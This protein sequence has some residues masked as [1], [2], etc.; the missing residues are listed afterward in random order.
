MFKRNGYPKRFIQAVITRTLN[1]IPNN[2]EQE[3]IF[4]K[5]PYVSEQLKRRALSVIRHSGILNIKTHFMNSGP[6]SKVFAP[7]REKLNCPDDCETCKLTLKTNCCLTKHVV[8]QVMCS[9]CNI[10]YIGETGRTVESRIKEHLRMK[11]QTVFVHLKSHPDNPLEESPFSW[12][13]LH[14]NVKSH[15]ERKIIEAL[16]LEIQ[17]HS[18]IMN[19]CIGRNICI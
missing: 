1:T 9:N 19:G 6:S 15:S 7:S 4:L 5:I 8:Y 12:K 13:I 16:V 11:K 2:D 10:T 18:D 3:N 17:K 14:S